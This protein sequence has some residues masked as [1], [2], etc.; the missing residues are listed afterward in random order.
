MDTKIFLI[1]III[2]IVGC[3]SSGRSGYPGDGD[4]DL[5]V[6]YHW[7]KNESGILCFT[8][9]GTCIIPSPRTVNSPCYCLTTYGQSPGW[10]L[11][12]E[13]S[14]NI[15]KSS[16]EKFTLKEV[17]FATNRKENP[18]LDNKNRFGEERGFLKYGVTR[19][20]IPWSHKIGE[21]ESPSLLRFE[22]KEDP[23]NH[24]I[25]L[26][27]E[28]QNS[29]SFYK[30][31]SEKT[32][33]SNSKDAF[34]FIHGYNVKFEEAAR[35][36]AQMSHDLNF[37]G[38]PVFFS[39][40]SHGSITKYTFDETNIK[41][42]QTDIEDFIENFA[43]SSGAENIYLIAHSMGSR[44]LTRAYISLLR[45]RPDLKRKFTE[46]ILA[47]PDIDADIFIRDI[48]PLIVQSETSVTLYASSEDKALK[49]SK[50]FHGG[51]ER[52]GESGDHMIISPGIET[53]DST[54]V[55]TGFLGHSY[56][57]DERSIINDIYYIVKKRLR[58]NERAGLSQIDSSKG[59]Y[60]EF[61]K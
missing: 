47:A 61:K 44:A 3:T 21:L 45:N 6:T 55:E 41:W 25:L 56:Y 10:V 32:K 49:A 33:N 29:D 46:I 31:I 42:A 2:L 23:E 30:T 16:N 53:I 24:I 13:T 15:D 52:A 43:I 57:A 34:I 28:V 26:E 17:Y 22:F 35:R 12:E 59:A 7:S 11:G 18:V 50:E 58:A 36:T 39:W 60:W 54:N 37:D 1:A 8:Q 27:I 51:Y 48:V 9:A 5:F 14:K 4:G 40:P 20:S 19:V 38:V